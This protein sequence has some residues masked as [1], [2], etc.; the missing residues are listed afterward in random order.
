M[1]APQTSDLLEKLALFFL[2]NLQLLQKLR[3]QGPLCSLMEIWY[4]W[5][6]NSGP[7]K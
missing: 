4:I 3:Y 5:S 2:Y 6:Y 1:F 7:D